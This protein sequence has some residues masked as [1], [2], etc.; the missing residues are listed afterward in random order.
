MN[1]AKTFG[2][3]RSKYTMI[4]RT[5]GGYDAR[6]QLDIVGCGDEVTEEEEKALKD[7]VKDE[8][9]AEVV[10][11]KEIV[12][13]KDGKEMVLIPAGSFEMGDHFGEG[14]DDER[15]VHT[16]ELDAFYMDIHEVTVGQFKEF[17]DQSGYSYNRWVLT[18]INCK[19][20]ITQRPERW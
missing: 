3:P 10:V 20:V 15:P 16:V 7:L 19:R 9:V 6:V 8:V 18:S 1:M 12:W 11:E 5:I 13:E 14:H 17:V 4:T 2:S